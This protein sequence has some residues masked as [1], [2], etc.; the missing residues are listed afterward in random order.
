MC[1]LTAK[2]I[3]YLVN[4]GNKDYVKGANKWFLAI[5][6]WAIARS[7][8]APCI[9]FSA[10]FETEFAALPEAEQQKLNEGKGGSMIPKIIVAGYNALDMIRYFTCGED[11][12][13]AWCIRN[14]TDAPRAAGVIHSD[15]ETGFMNCD[16]YN[17]EDYVANENSEQAVAKAGKVRVQGKK[18]IVQDG[19]ILFFVSTKS[20]RK[21]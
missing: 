20:S 7:P 9:P 17:Y 2:P 14:G 10:A 18:Y 19:D 15:F 1:M 4:V 12:V 16:Q 5:R 8:G 6:E 11:E 13:R 21:K 3:V